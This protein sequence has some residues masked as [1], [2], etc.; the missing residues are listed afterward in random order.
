M[1]KR[2]K[3]RYGPQPVWW[4]LFSLTGR[5]RRATFG[6]GTALVFSFW[7]IAL[8]QVF[9]VQEGT[10]R[11]DLWLLI[12]GFIVL[13]SGYCLYALAHKRLHDL[14]FPGWYA[15]GL[16]ALGASFAPL[17]IAPLIVLGCLPGQP[18]ENPFGPPPVR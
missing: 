10:E 1:A 9:A 4:A 13:G 15:V 16:V 18:K 14:G 6:L 7:W 3:G 2:T 12:L 11:H 5:I 17:V 8:S